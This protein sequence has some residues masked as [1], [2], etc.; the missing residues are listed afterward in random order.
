MG[1]F[2]LLIQ[3][4]FTAHAAPVPGTSSSL[5]VSERP[6]LFRSSH[7]FQLHAADTAWFLQ[8][9]QTQSENLET[10]Y[11][12]PK[13]SQG[14]QASLT[15]R[16]DQRDPKVSFKQYLRKSL[17]DYSRLGMDVLKAKPIKI[18]ETHGFLVDAIGQGKEKQIRQI[19][20]GKG[21]TMVI[22]T[23]RDN[24]KNFRNSVKE[25]NEILKSFQWL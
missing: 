22:L 14:L 2:F 3:L 5:L 16:V 20:F 17:K 4:P 1:L 15:V 6:Q 7:G 25:C 21:L 13:L 12:S 19:V 18:N 9:S 23:C 24:S 11:K 8:A 10:I